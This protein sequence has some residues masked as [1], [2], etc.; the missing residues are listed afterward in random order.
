[1]RSVGLVEAVREV[2]GQ[3][4][5]QRR[6]Y[7]SS[8][9]AEVERFA[10]AVRGHWE[11]ENCLHWVLD[12]QMGEDRC[13]VRDQK[14]RSESG[15]AT[16]LVPESVT[17][18]STGQ[19][20]NPHQAK[21]QPV[22]ITI[23]CAASWVSKCNRPATFPKLGVARWNLAGIITAFFQE[24]GPWQRLRFK[25]QTKRSGSSHASLHPRG[26][27]RARHLG[28]VGAR[29]RR[30]RAQGLRRETQDRVDGSVCGRDRFPK[31]QQLAA[32]RKPLLRSE[33]TS[34]ASK[35]R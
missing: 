12:V 15:G 19:T 30:G 9:P 10:A 20:G 35:G 11:I 8:L 14:C 27:H 25:T 4:S 22:G 3:V 21:R 24:S 26:R 32:R 1:L 33:I 23:T 16:G 31:I 13:A 34:S 28:R 7:L 5:T 6:Y 2:N 18:R 29:V 17:A